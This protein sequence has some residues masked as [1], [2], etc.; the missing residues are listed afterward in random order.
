M[1][2][3]DSSDHHPQY[4]KNGSVAW[5]K[6][7]EI[8]IVEMG[9][10]DGITNG[11]QDRY[12]NG[13]CHWGES[14][15]NGK[16]PNM[17]KSSVAPYAIQ[18]DFHLFTVIWTPNEITMYLDQDKYPNVKPYFSLSQAI[19]QKVKTAVSYISDFE[20]VLVD[21]ARQRQC[22]GVICGHIHH[23]EN[24]MIGGIHYLNSGIC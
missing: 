3:D 19:K 14:F 9:H 15:N 4:H 8:D 13:A 22:D 21:F 24:R 11:T 17:G 18:S 20:T 1:G 16:Y 5:P 10:K 6:C 7:G 2:D 23:P 12:F